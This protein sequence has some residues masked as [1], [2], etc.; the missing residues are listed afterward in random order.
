MQAS[1]PVPDVEADAGPPV[2]TFKAHLPAHS[3]WL[4]PLI[5]VEWT[6][7]RLIC[8]VMDWAVCGSAKP[9]DTHLKL[10]AHV[11]PDP[12]QTQPP[13]PLHS[14]SLGLLA[15]IRLNERVQGCDTEQHCGRLGG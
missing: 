9:A 8:C 14:E 6:G 15:G 11:G 10:G 3:Q 2:G 4:S 7:S 13:P 12:G 1:T 5:D